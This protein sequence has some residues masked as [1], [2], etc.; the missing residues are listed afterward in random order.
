MALTIGVDIGGTKVAAGVVDDHGTILAEERRDTPATDADAVV[1]TIVGAIDSLRA[2]HDV[3][4]VGLAAPGF[5][6]ETRSVVRLAPNIPGWRDRHL[7]ADVEQATGL[8][9]VVENDANAAAWAEAVHGAGQGFDDIVCITVGTGVGGGIIADGGL[10]RGR[11]GNAAE[12]GH[13]KV[14]ADGRAC[15]C[16]QRGCWEQYAS[17]NALL[18]EA[19]ERAAEARAEARLM[20]SLGNGSPEGIKGK[21]VTRAANDGDPV[22][23]AAFEAVGHWLGLGLADLAA[24]LDPACFVIGGGV[25]A[26]GDLLLE[27]ARRSFAKELTGGDIRPLAE[28][29]VARFGNDAGM[30][31]VADLARH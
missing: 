1:E 20:L 9:A 27:P 15:G 3:S 18:R 11:F 24:V 12:V 10:Y 21:H 5:V 30:I 14:L 19:R 23:L 22:A 26:A 17:G 28:V 16:G 4:A 13:M 29:R 6:D 7:K 31:G 25:S 8:R 2:K